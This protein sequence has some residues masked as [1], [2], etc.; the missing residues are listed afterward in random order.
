MRRLLPFPS[1]S[2]VFLPALPRCSARGL[3]PRINRSL[4]VAISPGPANIIYLAQERGFFGP[5]ASRS[6]SS[7]SSRSVTRAPRSRTVGRV[8]FDARRTA[9][10]TTPGPRDPQAFFVA[11]LFVGLRHAARRQHDPH[12]AGP[13]G[14]RVGL[15]ASSIDVIGVA[16]ARA[17][18]GLT[19][20]GRRSGSHAWDRRL[21]VRSATRSGVSFPPV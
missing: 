17:S 2:P 9:R 10:E 3:R 16:A 20:P 18:A 5:R 6:R 4:R 8:R 11:D 7:N 14:R 12:A 21:R 19:L 1:P 15:E 13:E